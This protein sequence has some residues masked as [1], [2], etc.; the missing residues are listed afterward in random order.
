MARPILAP[1]TVDRALAYLT[2]RS[3]RSDGYVL[4][5]KSEHPRAHKGW[6][7]EHILVAERILGRPLPPKA[8]VHHVDK[9]RSNNDPSNLVI[10]Q[11]D[12]YHKMLHARERA[13][14][15][16][17]DANAHK[18]HYCL[19]YERQEGMRTKSRPYRQAGIIAW[20]PE[21]KR[22]Y[23]RACYRRRTMQRHLSEA[24]DD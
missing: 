19:T 1:R 18:C 4:V 21:C 5:R 24:A 10:C 12:N 8:V 6:V 13:Y 17:G 14:L 16:C 3:T 15:A 2:G 22:Q 20:H 7:R 9:N 11:D 23:E